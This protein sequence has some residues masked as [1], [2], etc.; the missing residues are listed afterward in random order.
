MIGLLLVMDWNKV[1]STALLILVVYVVM[2]REIIIESSFF[3]LLILRQNYQH[4]FQFDLRPESFRPLCALPIGALRCALLLY[5]SFKVNDSCE[6][7]KLQK[8]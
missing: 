2:G 6:T 7:L 5:L 3:V 8:I 1:I 4:V